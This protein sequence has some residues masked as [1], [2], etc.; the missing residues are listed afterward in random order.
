[1]RDIIIRILNNAPGA[2]KYCLPVFPGEQGIKPNVFLQSIAFY[3]QGDRE[4]ARASIEGLSGSRE[5]K[6]SAHLLQSY[7]ALMDHDWRRALKCTNAL[8][9]LA[10]LDLLGQHSDL[11]ET[12][13]CYQQLIEKAAGA[14]R[15]S[16]H[17]YRKIRRRGPTA[18]IVSYPRSG[19][20]F[21]IECLKYIFDAPSYSRFPVDARYFSNACYN[22]EEEGVAIIKDHVYRPEYGKEKSVV[23]VRDGR[24]SM[25]SLFQYILSSPEGPEVIATM[26]SF[27]DFLIWTSRYYLFGFWADSIAL[28]IESQEA[29]A[30]VLFS[31]Y[32]D[33]HKNPQEILRIGEYIAP[34]HIARR[35]AAGM[36]ACGASLKEKLK[37]VP[38]WGFSGSSSAKTFSSW[39]ANR[40]GSNWR[41]VFDADARRTFHELG[42]T[43]FLIRFGYETDP[44]WWRQDPTGQLERGCAVAG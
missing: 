35:D 40:G 20:T 28:A 27:S 38:E 5:L 14:D 1:M 18:H 9:D 44:D 24:D 17:A 37:D 12:V 8:M 42:G 26:A 10:N 23:L 33:F 6:V 30:Q 15:P 39:S 43:E 13:A 25:V 11:K 4:G 29:G 31:K 41:G 22:D 36:L 19:N 21:V 32:E 34:D 2:L 16:L 3:A 7:Y